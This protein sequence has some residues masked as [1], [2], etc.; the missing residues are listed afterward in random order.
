MSWLFEGVGSLL[1]F[2][3]LGLAAVVVV[4]WFLDT[5]FQRRAYAKLSTSVLEVVQANAAAMAALTSAVNHNHPA[6]GP[7]DAAPDS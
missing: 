1:E 6:R 2:R 4:L 3:E 7:N 5:W